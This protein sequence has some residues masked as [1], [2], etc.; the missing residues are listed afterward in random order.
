MCLNIIISCNNTGNT[1]IIE[2]TCPKNTLVITTVCCICCFITICYRTCFIE[3][4]FCNKLNFS[5]FCNIV[6]DTFNCRQ[7]SI[8]N[9]S[10]QITTRVVNV[11]FRNSNTATVVSISATINILKGE[12]RNEV[13]CCNINAIHHTWL[14]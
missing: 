7:R 11:V 5:V 8:R 9:T 4:L 10:V 14:R 6:F 3:S 1:L 13:T 12:H 2:V